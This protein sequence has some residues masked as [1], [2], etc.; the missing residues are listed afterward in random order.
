VKIQEKFSQL[1]ECGKKALIVYLTAGLPD[2]DAM[3]ELMKKLEDAGVDIFEIG[4]P[5]SDPIADGPILQN[6]A[7]IALKKGV[8]LERIFQ[9]CGQEKEN[10]G[11][12]LLLMSY[13]NPVLHLGLS[14]FCLKCAETGVSGVIV[15]DLPLEESGR[16][17]G[18]LKQSGIDLIQFISS[19]TS[20]R[21]RKKI[22][23]NASGFIYYISVAGVTGPRDTLSPELK[24]H[25]LELKKQTRIPVAVGFGISNETQVR[26]LAEFAD[27]II[28]GSYA[29][30]EILEGNFA[31]LESAIRKFRKILD[32]NS[33]C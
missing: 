7:Q 14:H 27:G 6:A 26:Q 5:F 29:M 30:Q 2:F 15:P 9:F 11:V 3:R 4:V 23:Q 16:L 32:S 22:I 10:C 8:T 18:L 31:Q 33:G 25:V 13:Y 24:H 19:T 1:Q 21:R 12:P 20:A 28:I 17:A